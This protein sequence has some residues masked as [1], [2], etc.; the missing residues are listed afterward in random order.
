MPRINQSMIGCTKAV[1]QDNLTNRGVDVMGN[2]CQDWLD[3][4]CSFFP[5]VFRMVWPDPVGRVLNYCSL[6]PKSR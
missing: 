5:D 6:G 1:G 3:P 4:I 2:P